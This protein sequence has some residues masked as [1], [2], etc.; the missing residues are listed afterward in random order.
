M[1]IYIRTGENENTGI[2]FID[3]TKWGG[4]G[5]RTG[6]NHYPGDVTKEPTRYTPK[7]PDS[8]NMM[9]FGDR[10]LAA[11]LL[12]SH[13]L[14]NLDPLTEI[15]SLT[16]IRSNSSLIHDLKELFRLKGKTSRE[17]IIEIRETITKYLQIDTL[18]T[19]TEIN[20]TYGDLARV[21]LDGWQSM[22]GAVLDPAKPQG[23]TITGED[24]TT[25][26]RFDIPNC[27]RALVY[28]LPDEQ[29]HLAIMYLA[30]EKLRELPR[31]TPI[32]R[33]SFQADAVGYVVTREEDSND[34]LPELETHPVKAGELRD[35][36]LNI[37]AAYTE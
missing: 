29:R 8:L 12:A 36:L 18:R 5:S 28:Q 33:V 34:V 31:D 16:W 27:L 35:R 23:F 22:D 13:E 2:E 15:E 32:H 25:V 9:T 24:G 21:E 1:H 30:A 14:E 7:T 20:L 6:F 11:L 10:G 3:G 26:T 17:L 4:S 37:V 19:Q